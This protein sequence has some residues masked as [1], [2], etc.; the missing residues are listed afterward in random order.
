MCVFLVLST[1]FGIK[2]MN[3]FIHYYKFPREPYLISHPNGQSLY[4]FRPK[5]CKNPTLWGGTYMYGFYEAIS[6]PPPPLGA[7]EH[8]LEEP[9]GKIPLSNGNDNR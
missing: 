7:A 5:G 3:T 2:T 4:V 8:M 1:S 6:P 9:V